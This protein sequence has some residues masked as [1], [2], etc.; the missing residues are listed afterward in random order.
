M[1]QDYTVDNW[2]EKIGNRGDV[3]AQKFTSLEEMINPLLYL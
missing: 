1:D 2:E 3:L